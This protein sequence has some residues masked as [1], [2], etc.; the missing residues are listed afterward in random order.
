MQPSGS[1]T[2]LRVL[3]IILLVLS[4]I[5]ILIYLYLS[6]SGVHMSKE[7]TALVVVV[8]IIGFIT[9]LLLIVLSDYAG[10]TNNMNRF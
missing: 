2:A 6:S 4:I 9:G 7:G 8:F 5:V 1:K 10:N 3:G